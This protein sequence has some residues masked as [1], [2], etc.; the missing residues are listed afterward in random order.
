MD[1]FDIYENLCSRFA[2]MTDFLIRKMFRSI[3]NVEFENQGTLIDT[4]N[5][6]HKRGLFD[7]IDS[8]RQIK[9]LRNSIAHEYLDDDLQRLFE[10]V[11]ALTPLVIEI[12]LQTSDYTRRYE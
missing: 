11:V 12:A 7:S 3:D 1:E 9:D 6:A 4:V 8:L 2:R 10:N 5:N